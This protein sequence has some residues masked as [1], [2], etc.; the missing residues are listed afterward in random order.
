MP[1]LDDVKP[2]SVHLARKLYHGLE[3]SDV[4]DDE[5][6]IWTTLMLDH[7]R[8]IDRYEPIDICKRCSVRRCTAGVLDEERC[9][10]AIHHVV[11]HV[12]EFGRKRAVGG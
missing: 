2:I 7:G 10:L 3:A 1:T 11:A 5:P 9:L 4:I 8:Y 12:D 6:H